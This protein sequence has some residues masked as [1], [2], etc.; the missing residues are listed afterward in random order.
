MFVQV[1]LAVAWMYRYV[2]AGFAYK[3]TNCI[4]INV[5][6]CCLQG[7]FCHLRD[8]RT[9]CYECRSA[10]LFGHARYDDLLYPYM[11]SEGMSTV[12]YL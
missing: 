10:C 7:S 3:R 9:H 11:S 8:H 1:S 2:R 4:E 5:L 12:G 6:H